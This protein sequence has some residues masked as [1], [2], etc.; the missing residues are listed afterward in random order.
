M[1]FAPFENNRIGQT[2]LLPDHTGPDNLG[3]AD[4]QDSFVSQM[5]LP[6]HLPSS[7]PYPRQM[8]QPMPPSTAQG[9]VQGYAGHSRASPVDPHAVSQHRPSISPAMSS[10][11]SSSYDQPVQGSH[12]P[13][14]GSY[15]NEHQKAQS[16]SVGYPPY[17]VQPVQPYSQN[18]WQNGYSAPYANPVYSTG[19][20][21]YGQYAV[22]P[23]NQNRM[24]PTVNYSAHPA[25][26]G[27]SGQS[28]NHH[29]RPGKVP[30]R[31][32]THGGGAD[33]WSDQN[34]DNHGYA[35]S[36]RGSRRYASAGAGHPGKQYHDNQP[37]LPFTTDQNENNGQIKSPN[38]SSMDPTG[39]SQTAAA[40]TSPEPAPQ[41]TNSSVQKTP[42]AQTYEVRPTPKT[43]RE[44]GQVTPSPWLRSRRNESVVRAAEAFRA[45]PVKA[46]PPAFWLE[47][48]QATSSASS[49]VSPHTVPRP[50]SHDSSDGQDPFICGPEAS[51]VGPDTSA[52]VNS[53]RLDTESA[54]R[55][56]V[57]HA[58]PSQE[59][60]SRPSEHLMALC[61]NGQKPTVDVAFNIANIPFVEAARCHPA[62]CSTG[63][64]RFS[65]VS[66]RKN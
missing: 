4:S 19:H 13:Q 5:P 63:L 34:H 59:Q 62:K 18:G 60:A 29:P 27:N 49:D 1:A 2:W 11:F 40:P 57:P 48:E 36:N 64:V 53:D 38:D 44:L 8:Q 3:S 65:N 21:S 15:R 37:V 54:S 30:Y 6:Y 22:G 58:V 25:A 66:R 28:Q 26:H 9:W 35:S 45:E 17:A 33:N 41:A 12:G 47:Q 31:R 16:P 50:Q 23:Y 51:M 46:P 42:T 32:V 43:A 20:P 39:Y 7:S 52:V 24:Q 10:S 55:S 14:Y 61:P 56:I